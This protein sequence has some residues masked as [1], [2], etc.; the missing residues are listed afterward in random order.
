MN[1]YSDSLVR[2]MSSFSV[3]KLLRHNDDN[4]D[5][6]DASLYTVC[7]SHP[8]RMRSTYIVGQHPN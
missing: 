6:D 5:K 7:V 3:R 2:Q 4:D 1:A 8:G